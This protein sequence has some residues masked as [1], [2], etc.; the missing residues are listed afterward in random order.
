MRKNS[1]REQI[2]ETTADEGTS[3]SSRTTLRAK[4]ELRPHATKTEARTRSQK[5]DLRMTPGLGAGS[6]NGGAETR[7]GYEGRT[8]DLGGSNK[9]QSGDPTIEQKHEAGN[10]IRCERQ[11]PARKKLSVGKPD[12]GGRIE[13]RIKT[14][15][16]DW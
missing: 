3:P 12:A 16:S 6:T 2:V 13:T 14:N 10:R 15:F 7:T 9:N 11:N 8:L 1:G 5:T 4:S